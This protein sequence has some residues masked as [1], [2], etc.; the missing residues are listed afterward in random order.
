M[1]EEV[2]F[3]KCGT[4]EK[5]GKEMKSIEMLGILAV[6]VLPV[7]LGC[8]KAAPNIPVVPLVTGKVV[9]ANGK[10][11][12]A[13]KVILEPTGELRQIAANAR[14]LSGEVDKKGVFTIEGDGESTPIL[15]GEYKVFVVIGHDP[16]F[17][18][19]RKQVPEKY[20]SIS[21]DDSDLFV[22]LAQQSQDVVLKLKSS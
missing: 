16:R 15:A 6:S 8:G 22:D 10:P 1:P 19:V 3:G 17:K 4:F 21:E 11:L 12:P 14:R 20:Q 2:A 5:K 9:L 18:A 7:V 13:G